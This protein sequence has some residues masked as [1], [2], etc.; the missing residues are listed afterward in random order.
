MGEG[1]QCD[2]QIKYEYNIGIM[3][4]R[5]KCSYAYPINESC[6]KK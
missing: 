2:G 1:G 6:A 3:H 5:I 4:V